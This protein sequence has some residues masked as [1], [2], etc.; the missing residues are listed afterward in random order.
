MEI[1]WS[2]WSDFATPMTNYVSDDEDAFD[3]DDEMGWIDDIENNYFV[4]MCDEDYMSEAETEYCYS[5]EYYNGSHV[6]FIIY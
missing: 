3:T 1:A 5:D 2:T 6:T 4:Q